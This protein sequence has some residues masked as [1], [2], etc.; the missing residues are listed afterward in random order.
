M[1][2]AIFGHTWFPLN[3]DETLMQRYSWHWQNN[4]STLRSKAILKKKRKV[5]DPAVG[6]HYSRAPLEWV[7]FSL[8]EERGSNGAIFTHPRF[9]PPRPLRAKQILVSDEPSGYLDICLLPRRHGCEKVRRQ[10]HG[11]PA[12]T[13]NNPRVPTPPRTG[14]SENEH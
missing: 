14:R 1:K 3:G 4:G 5:S 6:R 10:C 13:C 7:C 2:L 9:A 11:L 12:T 8:E